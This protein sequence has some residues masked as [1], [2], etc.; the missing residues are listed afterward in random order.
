MALHLPDRSRCLVL[1]CSCNSFAPRSPSMVPE[2]EQIL[3]SICSHGVHAH[4][5]IQS[6]IVNQFI[7]RECFSFVQKT[8]ETCTCT[9]PLLD[10]VPIVN[11][12][13]ATHQAT[14]GSYPLNDA[15]STHVASQQSALSFPFYASMGVWSS[16]I[17]TIPI[18]TFL[19]FSITSIPIPI[20]FRNATNATHPPSNPTPLQPASTIQPENPCTPEES[21]R[22]VQYV[23]RSDTSHRVRPYPEPSER[24]RTLT[25]LGTRSLRELS[26]SPLANRNPRN[27]INATAEHQG[28]I[29]L[30]RL[31][32]GRSPHLQDS[33][34]SRG[35]QPFVVWICCLPLQC[36]HCY[37]YLLEKETESL[38]LAMCQNACQP[39]QLRVAREDIV[40]S[41]QMLWEMGLAFS[42]TIR[43]DDSSLN[44][45]IW[46]ALHRGIVDKF[47]TG[48][49]SIIAG[50][51]PDEA[52]TPS[53]S[54][55]CV[56]TYYKG[57]ASTP[58]RDTFRYVRAV[59]RSN[60]EDSHLASENITLSNIKRWCFRVGPNSP[61]NLDPFRPNRDKQ[62]TLF[63]APSNS[64][65]HGN[66]SR[67]AQYRAD[68]RF[69]YN[70]MATAKRNRPHSCYPDTVLSRLPFFRRTIGLDESND[71]TEH[72]AFVQCRVPSRRPRDGLNGQPYRSLCPQ[73]PYSEQ[74]T[75][76]EDEN[77][78]EWSS[79]LPLRR[80]YDSSI[81]S[82]S[83]ADTS[84][85]STL[86]IPALEY[87]LSAS[88][89]PSMM[90]AENPHLNS[91]GQV[92]NTAAVGAPR[93]MA[94][95]QVG[96]TF[97]RYCAPA[98]ASEIYDAQRK[99]QRSSST[100]VVRSRALMIEAQTPVNAGQAIH[101]CLS[102]F[103]RRCW[104]LEGNTLIEGP[105]SETNFAKL[106]LLHDR[107]PRNWH[108]LQ[109]YTDPNLT[110][111]SSPMA[112]EAVGLGVNIQCHTTM[113]DSILSSSRY[114]GARFGK[115]KVPSLTS[116]IYNPDDLAIWH[117][118]GACFALYAAYTGAP[119][120]AL[121][122]LFLLTLLPP[123]GSDP[124][125]YLG[126]ITGPLLQTL[127]PDLCDAIH[128]WF[129]LEPTNPIGHTLMDP[130]PQ[131][132][133]SLETDMQAS[134]TQWLFPR[135]PY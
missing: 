82:F 7:A 66:L 89:S 118:D 58:H 109:A 14:T 21:N 12:H 124:L 53:N 57:P 27:S 8:A 62:W 3:C 113:I 133:I 29:Q 79:A 25:E 40:P 99:V 32:L 39:R 34:R 83:E 122:P 45:N 117:A 102:E 24:A 55:W 114:V 104:D 9:A 10:H 84:D 76:D 48:T 61:P 91:T 31:L 103:Y 96:P 101:I 50:L 80:R 92:I 56:Q 77:L 1:N 121:H 22:L 23:S 107:P 126:D 41:I 71:L 4:A 130:V 16:T 125:R 26:P 30:N 54:G 81:E 90:P 95:F 134:W 129:Y 108:S 105:F 119:I 20:P 128:P 85:R 51:N 47:G 33:R 110:I 132:L 93:I 127:D 37:Q 38:P 123:P 15:T 42:L 75:D 94:P 11:P 43:P 64:N 106:P 46:T 70:F 19:P 135:I 87:P 98:S 49:S 36:L 52:A 112:E 100:T 86:N 115:F 65:L 72:P 111:L 74:S 116:R 2:D 67:L 35:V 88:P 131:A 60:A 63:I 68:L 120:N 5:D 18:I 78:P 6:I 17:P 44:A 28:H 97:S 59:N 13:R 69:P 73:N